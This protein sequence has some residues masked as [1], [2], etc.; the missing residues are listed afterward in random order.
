M[1]FVLPQENSPQEEDNRARNVL[2]ERRSRNFWKVTHSAWKARN[3]EFKRKNAEITQSAQRI[4]MLQSEICNRDKH[5]FGKVLKILL[6]SRTTKK[7]SLHLENSRS[8]AK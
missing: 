1:P 4:Y 6:K 2:P 7:R 3:E 5:I 8:Y